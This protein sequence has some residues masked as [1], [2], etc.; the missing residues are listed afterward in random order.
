MAKS[1]KQ[2]QNKKASIQKQIDG[3]EALY[4]AKL[5]KLNEDMAGVNAELEVEIGALQ[6]QID[7]IRGTVPSSDEGTDTEDTNTENEVEGL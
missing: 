6:A 4:Q 1:V 5:V 3:A 7:A 2:L